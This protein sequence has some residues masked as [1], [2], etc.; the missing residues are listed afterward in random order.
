MIDDGHP[1]IIQ[2][3]ALTNSLPGFHKKSQFWSQQNILENYDDDN[4][5]FFWNFI[6][7][8]LNYK[9]VHIWLV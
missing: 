5:N 9:I 1:I 4:N 6:Y 2:Y 7:T 3:I 8:P